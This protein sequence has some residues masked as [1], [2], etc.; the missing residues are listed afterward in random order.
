[1]GPNLSINSFV[2]RSHH[3]HSLKAILYRGVMVSAFGLQTPTGSQKRNFS[4]KVL[5]RLLVS[6]RFRLRL[7]KLNVHSNP[8][9]R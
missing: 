9:K 8:G 7:R 5:H 3:R 2:S 6:L 1:M 4:R